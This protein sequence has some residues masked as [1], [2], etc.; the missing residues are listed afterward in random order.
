M[1]AKR[2]QDAFQIEQNVMIAAPRGRVW[3]ALAREVNNWWSHR[4]QESGSVVRIEPEIGGRFFED[5]HNGDAALWGTV[6][7][8]KRPEI[9]RLS[10]PLGMVGAVMSTYTFQLT[11][12]DDATRL[13]LSHHVAGL[14]DSD[15]QS[16]HESGWKELWARL[17]AWVED[18]KRFDETP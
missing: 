1:S 16:A 12:Q 7:Y 15:W 11:E 4:F 6:T 5:F 13:T 8:V 2:V 17:R 18:G 10:G 9:L 3:D 14:L